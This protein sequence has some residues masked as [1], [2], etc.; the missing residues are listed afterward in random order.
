V[1]RAWGL[2]LLA[3]LPLALGIAARLPLTLWTANPVLYLRASLATLVEIAGGILSA[4]LLLV[5][6][7]L[8]RRRQGIAQA[9]AE[10]ADDRH[11]F[12]RRL[13]HQ[14]KNAVQAL[15]AGLEH[16][17]LEPL[18]AREQPIVDSLFSTSRR[19][20]R[21]TIGMR[22]LGELEER[23]L[24]RSSVN[25]DLLLQEAVTLVQG[26]PHAEGR[27]IALLVTRAPWPLPNISGDHEL[28]LLCVYNL[29]DNACKFSRPGDR[30][31][32]RAAAVENETAVEIQVADTGMGIP[33]E[34]LPHLGEELYRSRS[35][36][37]MPGSGI[38]L[39]LVR[40][41]VA[42]HGGH[43]NVDSRSTGG[44]LVTVRLPVKAPS[45]LLRPDGVRPDV[46]AR[47]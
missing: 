43:F 42:Q 39:A 19:L 40:M 27:E 28:L 4:L 16:L 6:W 2:A 36:L 21:L 47:N 15:L 11:R 18:P 17:R 33:E 23:P 12:M 46:S 29:L 41:V 32:L 22:K 20:A 14:L 44:T 37:P 5:I 26:E 45:G 34:D 25:L 8:E 9:R 7:L 38:G 24:E 30:V 1:R 10:M 3:L 35:A 31:E 13:D